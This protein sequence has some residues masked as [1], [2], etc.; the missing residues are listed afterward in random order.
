[1]AK[2]SSYRGNWDGMPFKDNSP[3]KLGRFGMTNF[4]S[5]S[6]KMKKL[7]CRDLPL[8]NKKKSALQEIQNTARESNKDTV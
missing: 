2:L 4:G 8:L 1:M 5:L 3:E 6:K 7:E